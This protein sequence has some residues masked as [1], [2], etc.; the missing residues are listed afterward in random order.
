MGFGADGSNEPKACIERGFL[1]GAGWLALGL[2]SLA[3]MQACAKPSFS[4]GGAFGRRDAS[5]AGASARG[6]DAGSARPSDGPADARAAREDPSPPQTDDEGGDVDVDDAPDQ[7]RPG[8]GAP[9]ARS[10]VPDA[11]STSEPAVGALPE[12]ALPLVGT[13][14]VRSVTFSFD[15]ATATAFNTRNVELSLLKIVRHGEELLLSRQMCSFVVSIEGAQG[16]PPLTFKNADSTPPMQGR[17]LLSATHTFSTEPI[18]QHLGFEPTRNACDMGSTRRAKYEDQTWLTAAT[19]VCS[20]TSTPE[21]TD[22]CRVIDGDADG[23][24]GITAHGP[25]P[26]GTTERDYAMVFDYSVTILDG[27][28]KANGAHELREVR[29]QEGACIN[30][31]VDGCSVGHNELCPGGSTQ[32]LPVDDEATCAAVSNMGAF[33]PPDAYPVEVDCRAKAGR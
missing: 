28:V 18:L 24:P 23:K 19:C 32:L 10:A 21:H 7:V 29:A 13:Y 9:D 14:A 30:T 6:S 5:S 33:G 27:Q 2:G 3:C 1:K 31:A 25:S 8:T 26:L 15:D 12:W 4:D 20:A 17:I 16:S 22:D 11:G